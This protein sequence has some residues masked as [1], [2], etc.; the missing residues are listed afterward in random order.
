MAVNIYLDKLPEKA[1]QKGMMVRD[2]CRIRFLTRKQKEAAINDPK[3]S[4]IKYKA[5]D[6]DVQ[7]ESVSGDR[8]YATRSWVFNNLYFTNGD[9]VTRNKVRDGV[10]YL[11][12]YNMNENQ[13][14]MFKTPNTKSVQFIVRSKQ[15]SKAL[16]PGDRVV[17]PVK[18]AGIDFLHPILVNELTFDKMFKAVGSEKEAQMGLVAAIKKMVEKPS[19]DVYEQSLRKKKQELQNKDFKVVDGVVV[20]VDKETSNTVRDNMIRPSNE[21]YYKIIGRI[22][23]KGTTSELIGYVVT[24]GKK[25]L[26]LNI[27]QVNSLVYNKKI[28]NAMLVIPTDKTHKP[29]IRG[30]GVV[31]STLPA[32]YR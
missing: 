13:V 4:K 10:I 7:F 21:A 3:H 15:G 18:L 27:S 25:N 12:I 17:Y 1:F 9:K 29:F 8:R 5:G 32:T 6:P 31:L 23:K 20:G 19:G 16:K 28:Q 22:I 24:N 14:A 30:L 11:T 26:P 2:I